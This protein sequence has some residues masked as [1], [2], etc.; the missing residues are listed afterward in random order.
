MAVAV[1]GLGV[2][3]L[4]RAIAAEGT[5]EHLFAAP[6]LT[7]ETHNYPSSF[8]IADFDNDGIPDIA[9]ATDGYPNS[10]IIFLRG[11]GDGTFDD[12]S[13][14]TVKNGYWGAVAAADLNGDGRIDLVALHSSNTA[15][16][17]LGNGDG[18]FALPVSYA[19]PDGPWPSTVLAADLNQD[20]ILDLVASN[21][22]SHVNVLPG[23]GDGTFEAAYSVPAGRGAGGLA[24]SDFD[25][26]GIPDLAV[27]ER[28]AESVSILLGT[29]DGQFAERKALPAGFGPFDLAVGDLNGDG[30]HDIAVANGG[31][32]C[33][34]SGVRI[35]S[36]VSIYTGD[37]VGD[38]E[39]AQTLNVG[40]L[41]SSISIADVDR[42]GRLDLVVANDLWGGGPCFAGG[43]PGDQ[44]RASPALASSHLPA[45][46]VFH[47]RG[48]GTFDL[49]AFFKTG[50][51]GTFVLVADL[52]RDGRLDLVAPHQDLPNLAVFLEN[53]DGSFGGGLDL[54]VGEGPRHLTIEDFN[55]DGYGDIAVA[56]WGSGTI[57]VILGNAGGATAE[58]VRST[59]GQHPTFVAPGDFDADGLPDLAVA[60]F[61]DPDS[62]LGLPGN[63][64]VAILRGSGDGNFTQIGRYPTGG[65]ASCV[66][67][68][69]L[70]EDGR[71]DLVVANYLPTTLSVF[72]GSGDG[73]FSGPQ[74]YDLPGWTAKSVD[75]ADFNADGH[76]DVAV[77]IGAYGT[78]VILGRGDGTLAEEV[79]RVAATSALEVADV[80]LDGRP[81]LAVGVAAAVWTYLSNGDG[82][83]S[84]PTAVPAGR[85]PFGIAAADLNSDGLVDLA[86]ANFYSASATVWL[87]MGT[88]LFTQRVDYGAGNGATSVAAGDLN[89][90][91]RPDLAIA[92]SNTNTVSIRWN[93]GE[94]RAPRG[95]RAFLPGGVKVVSA[96]S[97]GPEAV[98]HL[99]PVG[100]A[101][102]NADVHLPSMSLESPA[103][104][105]I[106]RIFALTQD[107]LIEVDTD[108]NGVMELPVRFASQDIGRLF[109]RING[110]A[111]VNAALS[112]FLESGETFQAEVQ[113]KVMGAGGGLRA[114]VAPSPSFG[115][116]TVYV[117]TT[118]LGPLSIRLF[119]VRGRLVRTLLDE[120]FSMAG[121]HSA[122]IDGVSTGGEKLP[123]G[124][125]FYQAK[126]AEGVSSG[127]VTILR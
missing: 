30:F 99:E 4:P 54:V 105:A 114:F 127:R 122:R 26:N 1:L 47:G 93:R 92:N 63:G 57:D 68:C 41:P 43:S 13:A 121:L 103:T 123:A 65:S 111:T 60:D 44:P 67:A 5:G 55:R 82:T 115:Q 62:A 98:F 19:Y 59:A 66:R 77:S 106:D 70:N 37:G 25:R 94:S 73:T 24:V 12:L 87:G 101:Y 27:A 125:Y 97:D 21:L 53:E 75:V 7:V 33:G 14:V 80:N 20:G 109:S 86:T 61:G 117:S 95:A 51:A 34:S 69:D 18:S 28:F 11:R 3:H 49:L 107:P 31:W 22:G 120:R 50:E 17:L 8:A 119:D 45:L 58:I 23:V 39:P 10:D 78:S 85:D 116:A 9:S 110:T 64:A 38:F 42:D 16:V 84:R 102:T 52:N 124:I 126:G 72:L 29:G 83:F 81:D 46:S 40:I 48:D 90:D 118:T 6:F 113:L 108:N 32:S 88:G 79:S 96:A 104:G 100:G 76:L 35:G 91:G 71:L 74:G 15:D 89:G 2:Q 112:G 36:T 56:C